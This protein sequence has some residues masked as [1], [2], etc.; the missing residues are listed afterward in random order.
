[1]VGLLQPSRTVIGSFRPS[2]IHPSPPIH[3]P[4]FATTFP[5]KITN[6]GTTFAG[7]YAGTGEGCERRYVCMCAGIQEVSTAQLEQLLAKAVDTFRHA[8]W[9]C[10][11]ALPSILSGKSR[12]TVLPFCRRRVVDRASRFTSTYVTFCAKLPNK[13]AVTRHCHVAD[14]ANLG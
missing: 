3:A 9:I 12:V 1:M 2:C 6:E 10:G 7:W 5:K 11:V 4:L 14:D 8:E 13:G